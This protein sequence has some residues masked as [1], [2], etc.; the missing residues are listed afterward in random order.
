MLYSQTY[1]ESY[2]CNLLGLSP[3]ISIP[4]HVHSSEIFLLLDVYDPPSDHKTRT[5]RSD[6]LDGYTFKLSSPVKLA[7]GR[8]Y[9]VSSK[10]KI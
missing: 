2:K 5:S 1:V 6:P 3:D 9:R 10:M 7:K 4:A 8:L